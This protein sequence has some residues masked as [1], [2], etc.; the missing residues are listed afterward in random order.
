VLHQQYLFREC[1]AKDIVDEVGGAMVS[2]RMDIPPPGDGPPLLWVSEIVVEFGP[3]VSLVGRVEEDDVATID[4][5]VRVWDHEVVTKDQSAAAQSLP[6]TEITLPIGGVDRHD[7][8]CRHH[9]LEILLAHCLSGGGVQLRGG[10]RKEK[11]QRG[12]GEG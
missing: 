3:E 5:R 1:S 7:D 6:E 8:V 2:H 10:Q 4:E 12:R 11:G 9:Q